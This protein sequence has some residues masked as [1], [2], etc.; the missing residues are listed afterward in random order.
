MSVSVILPVVQIF[1]WIVSIFEYL[2]IKGVPIKNPF[3][4]GGIGN[5]SKPT[6]YNVMFE[7]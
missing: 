4:F 7:N 1:V 3:H 6:V 5:R 2:E